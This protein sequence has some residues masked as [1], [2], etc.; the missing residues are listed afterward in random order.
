M[1]G[2]GKT[3]IGIPMPEAPWRREWVWAEPV[4]VAGATVY[5]LLNTSVYAPYVI[6]DLVEVRRSGQH[7]VVAGL[8]ERGGRTGHLIEFSADVARA[9]VAALTDEWSA[10]GAAV[11]GLAGPFYSVAADEA[12]RQRPTSDEL[13][14]LANEGTI[15]AFELIARPADAPRS[16]ANGRRS[17]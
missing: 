9:S 1:A 12:A 5:R 3:K 11:E 16:S 7:L 13:A 6:D 2:D 14:R 10:T 4:E 17:A 8:H 15:A